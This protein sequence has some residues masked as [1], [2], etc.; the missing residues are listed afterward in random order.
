MVSV[1]ILV[2]VMILILSVFT[3]SIRSVTD[4]WDVTQVHRRGPAVDRQNPFH[5]VG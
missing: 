2:P 4:S 1:I 3:T 5:E